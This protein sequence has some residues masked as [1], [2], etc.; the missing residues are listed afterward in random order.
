MSEWSTSATSPSEHMMRFEELVSSVNSAIRGIDNALYQF[1]VEA[2]GHEP[3]KRPTEPLPC[4]SKRQCLEHEKP[5]RNDAFCTGPDIQSVHVPLSQTARSPPADL[6]L[7]LDELDELDLDEMPATEPLLVHEVTQ[8]N[9][10]WD[11]PDDADLA[12]MENMIF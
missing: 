3:R 7:S 9:P 1:Y 5:P 11:E 12:D 4:S 6:D 10:S 2:V 8:P